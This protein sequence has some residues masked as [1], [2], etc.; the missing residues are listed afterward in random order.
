M[1]FFD[2]VQ[3][4]GACKKHLLKQITFYLDKNNLIVG[5]QASYIKHGEV[6][7]GLKNIM[8]STLLENN[9]LK[10]I[11]FELAEDDYIRNI[12]GLY[13]D[14][15]EYLRFETEKGKIFEVGS[16]NDKETPKEFTLN[17]RNFDIPVTVFGA[18]DIKK[19]NIFIIYLILQ[20]LCYRK[21]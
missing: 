14:W 2:D 16:I 10:E 11:I 21:R 19:G 18:L 13:L 6:I 8:A 3:I 15:I 1:V 17:I 12:Y 9:G 20:S 4:I 5:L 7:T